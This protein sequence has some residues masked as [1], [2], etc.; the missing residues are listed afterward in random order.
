MEGKAGQGRAREEK[1]GTG[2]ERKGWRE[3]DEGRI[4]GNGI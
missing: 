3:K 4:R 2:M 1:Q